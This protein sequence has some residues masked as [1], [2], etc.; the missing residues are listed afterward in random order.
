MKTVETVAQE[1]ATCAE[2]T[3][4]RK[5]AECGHGG[6]FH[7]SNKP[8]MGKTMWRRGRGEYAAGQSAG[9]ATLLSLSKEHTIYALYRFHQLRCM[10]C[11]HYE[12]RLRPILAISL[13]VSLSVPAAV[14]SF[15]SPP[16]FFSCSSP[17][18]SLPH[19][20]CHLIPMAARPPTRSAFS[21]T[22][23]QP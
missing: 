1:Q 3:G 18:F 4:W 7:R 2:M 9:E 16:P 14:V 11:V 10:L 23:T 15:V 5:G 12:C 13:A 6:G 19:P 20:Q 21:H 22:H 17:L 8:W